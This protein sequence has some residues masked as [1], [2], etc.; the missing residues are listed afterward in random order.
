MFLVGSGIL[1]THGNHPTRP[2]TNCLVDWTSRVYIYIQLDIYIICILYRI[3]IYMIKIYQNY[4]PTP[5]INSIVKINNKTNRFFGGVNKLLFCFESWIWWCFTNLQF[6]DKSSS[7][8]SSA[9]CSDNDKF[10]III[11]QKKTYKQQHAQHLR[12]VST[13]PPTPHPPKKITRQLAVRT[14]LATFSTTF[15]LGPA[16]TLTT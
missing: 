1:A 16:F 3:F 5:P 13:P 14:L 9:P 2:A 7:K 15:S 11:Q 4:H 6:P 12:T 10:H 8:K